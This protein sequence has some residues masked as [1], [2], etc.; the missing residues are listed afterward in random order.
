MA[1]KTVEFIVNIRNIKITSGNYQIVG[2]GDNGS[3]ISDGTFQRDT[4]S[5][6]VN[7]NTGDYFAIVVLLENYDGH[8]SVDKKINLM[9]TFRFSEINAPVMICPPSSIASIYTFAQMTTVGDDGFLDITGTDRNMK[10]AYGMKQNFYLT[11]GQVAHMISSSPNGFETNSYSMFNSL[12]N[13]L[14]HSLTDTSFYNDFLNLVWA[15]TGNP[16]TSFLGAIR[17]LIHDPFHNAS[18]IYEMLLDKKEVYPHSLKHMLLPDDKKVPT[19]WTLTLKSNSSGSNNFIPSGLAYVVFDADDNAW[20]GN[21]F[22]AGGAYSA[23]HALV[24]QYNATPASFSPVQGGGL[25]GVGFGTAVSPDKTTISFGNF[26]WGPE[27]NNPQEGSISKFNYSDGS[28]LSSSNGITTAQLSRVQGMNYDSNGN[29]WMASIGS[30]DPFAPAPKGDYPFESLNSAVVV[31]LDDDPKQ[32]LICDT[33]PIKRRIDEEA[34]I[35]ST[36]YLKVFD[37]CP[38]PNNAETAFVSCIGTFH[39]D[40][41]KSALSAV[42]KV[43]INRENQ[44]I[45]VISSWF[46]DFS[47]KH[48]KLSGFESLRQVTTNADGNAIVV[49]IKSNRATVLHNDLSLGV[50]ARYDTETY[51]PWG[52]KVDQNGTV[53]LASFA[54]DTARINSEVLD[55]QG[56]FGVTMLRDTSDP[57]SAKLLTVPTGGSEVTLANGF[58]LYGTLGLDASNN[59]NP[60]KMKCFQPLM[61]LTSTNIDG[62]GNLWCMNNWKP[63]TTVDIKDNPGGDGPVI[64]IGIAAPE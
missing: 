38:D 24:Y 51:S 36:P 33:F 54:Q 10:I 29:L 22:R 47:D 62:A 59:H 25:L 3:V 21:N 30:Q 63:A 8:D 9:A 52:V 4:F 34:E 15:E 1:T 17:N 45:D 57:T 43:A 35:T 46:S 13:L 11:E 5:V 39:I 64:F 48:D 31:Y 44:S 20:I 32:M 37:V 14:H 19:N 16:N 42:Y 49:G 61:R 53:F 7:D 60:I 18:E 58:P 2:I 27:F 55:M 28:P 26:G 6:E 50:K 12:C 40:K 56:P 41:E 23:T